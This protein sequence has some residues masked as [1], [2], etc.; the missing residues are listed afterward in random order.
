MGGLLCLALEITLGSHDVLLVVVVRLLVIVIIIAGSN[1]NT[2]GVP[3][4]L[5]LAF[6]L[7][8]SPAALGSATWL[9]SRTIFPLP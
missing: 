1:G 8:P 9:P 5:P 3:L 2:L 4:L 6:L 7:A